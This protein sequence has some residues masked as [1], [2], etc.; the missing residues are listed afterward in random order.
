VKKWRER[1]V[2]GRITLKDEL[3]QEDRLKTIVVNLS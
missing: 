2:N 1:L 3:G